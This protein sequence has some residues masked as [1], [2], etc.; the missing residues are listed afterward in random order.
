MSDH[1]SGPRALAEP[2][3]D[4]TDVYAFPS[5]ERP[6][7]LVLVMNTL[8]F[9]QPEDGL[10][11]GLVYRFRLRPLIEGAPGPT[12]S[13]S[14]SAPRSS[15]S[16]ASSPRRRQPP[17]GRAWSRRAPAS[18]RP[19]RPSVPVND[20]QGGS[21]HGVRVFAGPRWDPFIMDARAALTTIAT[22]ELS[23]TDPG[24]I[25]LDGK[26]VL[27]LVVEVDRELLGGAE[28]VGVVAETLTR[29]RFNVRIERVG[30]PEVKNMMLAP[31]QFDQVNRDLE[32]RDLYN[33][34]DAFHLGPTYQGAYRARLNANLAFWDGLDGRTDWPVDGRGDHPLT[35]LVLADYLVVDVT[36][37]YSEQ[38][39]FLEIELA[40]LAGKAH[41]TCG[42]RALNDDVIDTLFTHARQRRQRAG[43]QGRRRPGDAARL[44]HLPVSR[45][46][47]PGSARAPR[48]RLEGVGS[49]RRDSRAGHRPR[50]G[51]HPDR[52][53][54]RAT[55]ALR[56]DLPPA[57]HRRPRR[58][59]RPR[60]A[61]A[62]ARRLGTVHG[63][64]RAR[65]LDHRRL[66]LLRS[67]RPSGSRR[68]RWTASR[69]SSSRGWPH[70]RPS[71]ATSVRATPAT[72]RQPLGTSDVHVAVAVLSPD[73]A[74]LEAAAEKARR[75]HKELAGIELIWRQD[76]YQLP[77][78]RTS[79]GFKDG[80]GQPAV[81]GSGRP[82]SHPSEEPLKAGEIVLG[83][84][85]ETGEL[86][87][88]PTPEV[89]GRNGTYVVFRKL[90]TRVA[91]YRQYLR[92][93]AASR[94]DE[95]LLG[96]KMVGRWQ[97]G[98]PLAVSPDRDDAELG[99]DPARNNDFGYADDPRGLQ[100]PAGAHA[101]RANPRDALD[102]DGSVNVRLHRMIRRGTS[103]GPMLPDG[104]LEDDGV[105]RGIV[106]VFVGAHLRRQFEFVKTQWLNDGIFIGAP[107]EKDPLV[108]SERR[109]GTLHDPPDA[110]PPAAAG[111][112][113]VRRHPRRRVLLRPRPER[114]ALAGGA[115]HMTALDREETT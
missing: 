31:K 24:S 105:D 19:A 95:A 73:A 16:T 63:P 56:R 74:R 76:C 50:A 111:R 108:G 58:R 41:E 79:F 62:A 7:H 113:A 5:P 34:E 37:P 53:A 44:A 29:G 9:A 55:L 54:A 20:E 1:I 71:W 100:C 25:F 86:P 67:R 49:E 2:I 48:P 40:A 10:S 107:A 60:A 77:N 47:E 115:R 36:K 6:G 38:G 101:R 33:L 22:G 65:R 11:D 27:S 82:S 104:V 30:R 75:A 51:R 17:V 12:R 90:H 92:A 84:P 28:L 98:A 57:A 66:H 94:E 112:A 3:A 15:S 99:A 42:G 61:T 88:M 13:R 91:A 45:G 39:S 96:A 102:Q 32:I 78:G 21:G 70:A 43:H 87:P 46:A 114:P 8:P 18:P 23:F 68:S 26:N 4:I 64:S 80:I 85:D 106:F 110:D 93:K 109:H 83:Y 52:G 35:S 97:S 103:Y 89:L 59:A 72:G 81:E 69:R 14:P